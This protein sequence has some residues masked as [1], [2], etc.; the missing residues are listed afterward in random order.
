MTYARQTLRAPVSLAGLGLHSGVP[1]S[2]T[3]HP[4]DD[5]IAFRY[6]ACRMP[7]R[8]ENVSETTRCTKLG[9][10]ATI[11]H[12]MSAFAGLEITDAEVE[13]TAPEM[14]G[15]DGSAGGYVDAILA[16]GREEIG[17][18]EIPGLFT[19]LFLQEDRGLKGAIAKGDG[20][21][22]YVYATDA[23]WPFEQ[24]FEAADVIGGYVEEIARA[25]TFA[26]V[27]ELPMIRQMGLGQGLDETSALI[28][29]SEGYE[30]AARFPDEPA[31]HKLLDL[32]GDLYLAG[33]PIR[34]LSVVGER[35]GH[36]ANVMLAAMLQ[37]ALFGK[38]R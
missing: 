29:G 8:P 33:V 5:G 13:L 24:S 14:P 37:Q 1:V 3:I 32:I 17:R 16:A 10:V 6:G 18:A 11:E 38:E 36:R 30:N 25:R 2:V 20:H 23:R 15:L 19:R 9:D 27:E 21:W 4:G 34:M 26:L 22:R 7:A 31:R 12:L 35:T 28:L